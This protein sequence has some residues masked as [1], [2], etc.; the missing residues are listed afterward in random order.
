VPTLLSLQDAQRTLAA[1]QTAN[2][3]TNTPTPDLTAI[4]D[5]VFATQTAFQQTATAEAASPTP[6]LAD[7]QRTETAIALVLTPQPTINTTPTIITATPGADFTATP[8]PDDLGIIPPA[9]VDETIE[10]FASATPESTAT[11][12]FPTAP[13]VLP[14][15]TVGI[16]WQQQIAAQ[17]A[18]NPAAVSVRDYTIGAVV[19]VPG[20]AVGVSI[21]GG[22]ILP[23]LIA[24]NPV[25]GAIART[26]QTGALY[27]NEAV[28]PEPFSPYVGSVS[29]PA[30]NDYFVSA[31][32]WSGDGQ[33]LAF[34]VDGG[35][36]GHPDPTAEDGVHIFNPVT[37]EYRQIIVDCPYEGHQGCLLGG[38]R[39]YLGKT[40]E[41][42]WS[43]GGTRLIA[44]QR[45]NAEWA[46][47][48]DV[49]RLLITPA[50]QNSTRQPLTLAYDYGTWTIDGRRVVVSGQS[51]QNGVIIGTV[52]PDGSDLNVILDGSSRGLW[53]Q[54]AAQRRDGSFVALG[55]PVAEQAV[56]IIDQNGNFLTAPI[57]TAAPQSVAWNTDRSAVSVIAGGRQYI[58]YTDGRVTEVVLGSQVPGGTA[59]NPVAP[60]GVRETPAADAPMI[61][62]GG[63]VEGSRYAP[64][65]QIQI[66]WE[67]LNIRSAPGLDAAFA[68]AFLRRGQYARI[69]AGPIEVDG[70]VWWQVVATTEDGINV[71]GWV[72]GSIGTTDT[73]AVAP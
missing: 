15:P 20:A 28:P 57:G 59:P 2:A 58:A 44:R 62:P 5:A 1:R 13:P 6:D 50:D 65:Q 22:G 24:Q 48:R 30:E 51:P 52:N 64:G 9:V 45:L 69:L 4:A 26:S 10:D 40:T 53:M 46:Q 39:D 54:H 35:L 60:I 14:P 61:V 41:L 67:Q 66:L 32:A 36:G 55:R 7:I 21:G 8:L 25:T 73:F 11:I 12:A 43:P 29:S 56:R 38:G 70:Y 17:Q 37:G 3:P 42:H 49:G 31:V 23:L 63:V 27:V 68:G 19:P 34:V 18:G 71:T 16:D 72:A 33:Y 47:E